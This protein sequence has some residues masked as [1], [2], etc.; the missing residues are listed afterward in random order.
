VSLL[1]LISCKKARIGAMPV[2]GPTIMIGKAV[3]SG[4]LNVD[5]RTNARHLC[6]ERM[7]VTKMVKEE[8]KKE[9][10]KK[11]GEKKSQSFGR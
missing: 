6:K 4:S 3:S 1:H 10:R 9:K 2:P 8:T 5:S 11:K 7:R